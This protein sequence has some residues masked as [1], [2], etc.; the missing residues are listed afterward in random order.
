MESNKNNTNNSIISEN[1]G[2]IK[3][4][5]TKLG[6]VLS[7]FFKKYRYFFEK[8]GVSL[9]TLALSTILLFFILRQIPGDILELYALKLQNQQ[10]ITYDRAYQRRSADQPYPFSGGHVRRLRRSRGPLDLA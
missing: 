4:F 10:G 5:F 7:A 6:K 8:V 3:G 9:L 1:K 2:T